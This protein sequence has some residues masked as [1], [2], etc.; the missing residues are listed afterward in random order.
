[1]STYL[2]ICNLLIKQEILQKRGKPCWKG[3]TKLLR[4]KATM[5][6]LSERRQ[7]WPSSEERP[8]PKPRCK[9]NEF[10]FDDLQ[11]ADKTRNFAKKREVPYG[12]QKEKRKNANKII[13]SIIYTHHEGEAMLEREDQAPQREGNYGLALIEKAT[14]AKF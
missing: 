4:E 1:M 3:T 5:A 8:W 9:L 13:N 11:F 14:M 7:R 10:I 2:T 12:I 6:K